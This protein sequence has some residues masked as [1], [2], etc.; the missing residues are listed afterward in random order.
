M[1]KLIRVF[2]KPLKK[3]VYIKRTLSILQIKKLEKVTKSTAN[4]KHNLR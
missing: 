4:K 3:K 1:E 2:Y